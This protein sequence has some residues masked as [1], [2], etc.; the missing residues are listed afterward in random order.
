M[1]VGTSAAPQQAPIQ[2]LKCPDCNFACTSNNQMCRHVYQTCHTLVTCTQCNVRL[3]CWGFAPGVKKLFD[4]GRKDGVLL[5]D[6]VLDTAEKHFETT[7]HSNSHVLSK[8]SFIVPGPPEAYGLLPSQP[9]QDPTL[10]PAAVR[11]RCPDCANVISTWTQ[12]TRHL[13][14]TKHSLACCAECGVALKCYGPA[15]P[16][17]HEK[18]TGHR[19]ILGTFRQKGDYAMHPHWDGYYTTN[20]RWQTP[21]YRCFCGISFLHSLHLA[22]HL[23]KA[24]EAPSFG[25]CSCQECG[26]EGTVAEML[27][28]MAQNETHNEIDIP[29]LHA[30]CYLHTGTCGR[31]PNEHVASN[32]VQGADGTSQPST[33]DGNAAASNY[34]ILYQCPDCLVICTSWVR[35]EEHLIR[36]KHGLSFCVQ[37][38]RFLRPRGRSENHTATSGHKNIVGEHMSRRDYE[39]LVNMDDP[40]LVRSIEPEHFNDPVRTRVVFQCP[41]PDCRRVYPALSQLNDHLVATRHATMNC[42]ECFALVSAL[43]DGGFKGHAHPMEVPDYLEHITS[44]EDLVVLA[45]DDQLIS[46]FGSEYSKCDNC[47]RAV[48]TVDLERH[49]KGSQCVATAKVLDVTTWSVGESNSQP[50]SAPGSFQASSPADSMPPPPA[51]V[52]STIASPPTAMQQPPPPPSYTAPPMH[53]EPQ[54][55]QQVQYI[56]PSVMQQQP[57]AWASGPGVAPQPQSHD[58]QAFH[59]MHPPQFVQ[60]AP[61]QQFVWGPTLQ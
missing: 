52:P 36:L 4:K 1:P 3:V 23:V 12:M 19:G 34:R 55:A 32:I 57:W 54:Q 28:H 39:V 33:T 45:T 60:Q 8:D 38:D 46:V 22:E 37:C 18:M 58:G 2:V 14:A 16:Q 31:Y 43:D 20:S 29:E 11:F 42:P 44:H 13:D 25:T 15:Q 7:Q 26:M 6:F 30:E 5:E 27:I 49:T 61:Q 35:L 41:V 24:H 17:R 56:V 47:N 40:A 59:V 10:D 48:P 9:R 51:A 53:A 50:S 21:Q